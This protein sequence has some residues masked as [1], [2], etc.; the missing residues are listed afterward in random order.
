MAQTDKDR[1]R[2]SHHALDQECYA[3][4]NQQILTHFGEQGV[5]SIIQNYTQHIIDISTGEAE[6]ADDARKKVWLLFIYLFVAYVFFFFFSQLETEGN[7]I[8]CEA[9]KKT[10]S[11]E[12]YQ[13]AVRER[14]EQSA[15][16]DAGVMRGI[17]KLKCRKGIPAA[18]MV[19]IYETLVRNIT[20]EDQLIEFLAQ[21]PEHSG[22][23]FPV[24]VALFHP[25]ETVRTQTVRLLS[26]MDSVKEGSGFLQSLNYFL[27]LAY[28][29]LTKTK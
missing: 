1:E 9:W 2:E 12:A 26:T 10:F 3:R 16:K 20:T 7:K 15:I 4:V 23:L 28:D 25:S 29:R 6:Y 19:E 27:G 13:E 17:R 22:G 5:R 11:F 14:R 21:F 8:R 24:A 18:E